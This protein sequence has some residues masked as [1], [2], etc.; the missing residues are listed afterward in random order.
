[1][2]NNYSIRVAR[3]ED[4]K[5]ILAIYE[6]FI[7]K[8]SVTFEEKAPELDAFKN[9][10]QDILK[11]CP[12]LVCEV[13]GAVVGYAYASEYRTRAAYRWDREVSVYIHPDYRRKNVAKA[14]YHALFRILEKQGF[15]KL[16]GV[17]TLP[18]PGSIA[19]HEA[20]GFNKMAVYKDVGYK[21]GRWHDVG[22]WE[23]TFNK[24]RKEY[25]RELISFSEIE[26]SDEVELEMKNAEAILTI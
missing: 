19:L 15:V 2:K 7:L 12:Y 21:L 5:E 14:L 3:L 22:W 6:P 16:Y 13:D 9:R 11:S 24:N 26:K 25:P 4:A 10:M 17:I 8:T 1:M 20:M 18:N 23:L